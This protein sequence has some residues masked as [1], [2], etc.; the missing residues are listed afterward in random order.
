M[1]HNNESNEVKE[2]KYKKRSLMGSLIKTGLSILTAASI[3]SGL[4]KIDQTEQ[5]V[6]TQFGKP[7]KI[8][9]NPI[10]DD[11]GIKLKEKYGKED[12]QIDEGPGLKLKIPFIQKV[13]RY[14]RRLLRWNGS[15]E[16]I[17]TKDKKYIWVDETARWYIQDPLQFLRTVGMEAQAHS[18]LDDII[19][20]ATRNSIT[21][22]DLIEIVRTDNRKTEVTEEE[23]RETLNV[24]HVTEGRPK[25]VK[26]I[27]ENSKRDC[28]KYGIGI[29]SE[30]ILIKG[31]TYVKSVKIAVEERMI[32]E[33]ERIAE[34]YIS[35]GEGEYERIMGEKEKDVKEIRSAAYKTE[36]ETEGV[37]DAEAVK[38]YADGFSKNPEFY[39]F[40]RTLALYEESL[41]GSRL[42][43]G[44]DNPLLELMKNP[45]I[46]ED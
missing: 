37:A 11:I 22:R 20:A 28:E 36:R 44:T 15:R 18:R 23:L 16:E 9:L 12:I 1:N 21:N 29:H 5:A 43:I 38:I 3:Y 27:T 45:E 39:K 32:A 33:R 34:R 13:K 19:D 35:E 8:V 25:I 46:K 7:I 30:G 14:D 41:N 42:I 17:P 40:T 31:L 6:I 10:K 26:E 4:Y 2:P 24:G